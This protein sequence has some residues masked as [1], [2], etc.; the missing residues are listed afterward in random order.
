MRFFECSLRT[1]VQN[2]HEGE[3]NLLATTIIASASKHAQMAILKLV[4]VLRFQWKLN[5]AM[6][7]STICNRYRHRR[8]SGPG[9]SGLR[10]ITRHGE[11]GMH[12]SSSVVTQT[13]T[14]YTIRKA[15]QAG[16][17]T[18][19]SS[20]VFSSTFSVIPSKG[21]PTLLFFTSEI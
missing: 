16:T 3:N 5:F 7:T 12:L 15:T 20:F 1:D 8:A 10:G 14:T 6:D 9:D 17:F 4:S 18:S 21:T 11:R 13:K 2:V 19:L